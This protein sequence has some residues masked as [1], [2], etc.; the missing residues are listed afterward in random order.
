MEPNLFCLI[1]LRG[2]FRRFLDEDLALELSKATNIQQNSSFARKKS[3]FTNPAYLFLLYSLLGHVTY[4][5][6]ALFSPLATNYSKALFAPFIFK[7]TK[8]QKKK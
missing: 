3:R 7:A 2:Y 1:R 5:R 8:Q 4:L 6:N